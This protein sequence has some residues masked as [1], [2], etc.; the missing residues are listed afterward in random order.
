MVN[1]FPVQLVED[2]MPGTL[3]DIQ[4]YPP[5]TEVIILLPQLI[6]SPAHVAHRVLAAALNINGQV[7]V[8][9]CQCFRL[10]HGGH[11]GGEVW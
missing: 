9:P 1:L 7:L 6:E 3:I 2:L 10:S 11:A 4:L 5:D 8:D